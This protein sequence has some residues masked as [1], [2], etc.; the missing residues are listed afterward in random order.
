M[1]IKYLTEK[2]VEFEEI[3]VSASREKAMEIFTKSGQM[4][5]PQIEIYDKVIVGFNKDKLE[6]ELKVRT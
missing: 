1:A 4:A 2:G 3:D 5:V 6:K